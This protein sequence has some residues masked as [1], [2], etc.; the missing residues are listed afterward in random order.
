[1]I[2]VN[3]NL[4]LNPIALLIGWAAGITLGT[5]MAVTNNFQAAY[6]LALGDLT[7]PGY[8]ALYALITNLVLTFGLSKVLG[9]ARGRD[10]TKASDYNFRDDDKATPAPLAAIE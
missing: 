8:A 7:V 3:Y 2:L 4:K 6:P 9:P 1:V 10:E 5:F